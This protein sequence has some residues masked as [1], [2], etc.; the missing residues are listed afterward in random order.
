MHHLTPEVLPPAQ[1]TDFNAL[2]DANDRLIKRVKAMGW[3]PPTD[4]GD[5]EYLERVTRYKAEHGK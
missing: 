4:A 5:K 1:R 2:Y 3:A